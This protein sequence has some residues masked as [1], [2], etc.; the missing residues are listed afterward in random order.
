MPP[1]VTLPSDQPGIGVVL[2][3]LECPT[4]AIILQGLLGEGVSIRLVCLPGRRTIPVLK[5]GPRQTLPMSSTASAPAS[6]AEIAGAAGIELWR[7]G[8]LRSDEVETA[9]GEVDADLVVVACYHQLLPERLYASRR[10]GGINVHPSLLPDKRGPDPL[11]WV[12]RNGDRRAGS[13]VH[14]LTG[15]FDAGPIL[16]QQTL[17]VTD[18]ITETEL[19]S[20][21]A[22][23]G[24]SQL[25]GVITRLSSGDVE[26]HLQNDRRATWAPH[27]GDGDFRLDRTG[28]ARQAFNFARGIQGAGIPSRSPWKMTNR[29]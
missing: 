6:A 7:L 13:T 26:E 27:P 28:P 11:F 12:F 3:G 5:T 23:L 4:T 20:R 1:T 10:Y 22:A 19:E 2:F 14:R 8:D 9:L 24:A 18:G 21:L 29:T 16:D 25:I 15:T 17:D